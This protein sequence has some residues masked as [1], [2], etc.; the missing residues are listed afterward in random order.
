MVQT[1]RKNGKQGNNWTRKVIRGGI[2]LNVMNLIGKLR[3]YI[4]GLNDEKMKEIANVHLQNIIA[5]NTTLTEPDSNN[6]VLCSCGTRCFPHQNVKG[7][8]DIQF[9]VLR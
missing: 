3:L 4:N 9:L 2:I 8:L 6:H 7:G 1:R 5:H